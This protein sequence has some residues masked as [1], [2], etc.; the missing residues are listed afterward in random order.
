MLAILSQE[1]VYTTK[2]GCGNVNGIGCGLFWHCMSLDQ[3]CRQGFY[4]RINIH[5]RKTSKHC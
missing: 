3:A 4:I 1:V 2:S 5:K